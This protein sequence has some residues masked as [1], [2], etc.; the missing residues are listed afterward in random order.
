MS[1]IGS[2]AV[3]EDVG[4]PLVLGGIG[5]ARTDVAGLQSLEVLE[6]AQFIGHFVRGGADC[7]SAGKLRN[8]QER[9]DAREVEI[10]GS[11]RG[12]ISKSLFG[13]FA[14]LSK[15]LMIRV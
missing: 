5:V 7:S 1:D 3:A 4:S 10:G 15:S 8:P 12:W 13:H 6:R 9:W 2:V 11:S 14:L